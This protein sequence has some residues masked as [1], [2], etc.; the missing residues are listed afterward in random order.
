MLVPYR[1]GAVDA[2]LGDR[3]DR[4]GGGHHRQRRH[5]GAWPCCSAPSSASAAPSCRSKA[6]AGAWR[7]PTCADLRVAQPPFGRV[8]HR[9]ANALLVQIAQG[10]ACNRAHA[11]EQRC[12]RWLLQTHDRSEATIR[13][14]AGIPGTDAGRAQATVNQVAASLQQRGLIQYTRGRIQVTDREG[15]KPRP[16]AAMA[17]CAPSTDACCLPHPHEP[18]HDLPAC[19]TTRRPR[20]SA[21]PGRRRPSP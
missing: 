4:R 18:F 13:A 9:Y 10:A 19:R 3:R 7:R 17:S 21:P 8:L 14:H 15:W 12:A 6:P 2:R 16:V 11:V 1:R 5:A 20:V